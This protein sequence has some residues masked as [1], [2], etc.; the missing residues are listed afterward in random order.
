MYKRQVEELRSFDPQS[1]ERID[2]HNVGRIIRAIEIYR[3]TGMTMTEH[4]EQSRRIPSPYSA[5]II[6]LED[7]YKRQVV[8]NVTCQQNIFLNIQNH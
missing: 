4:V 1:A 3:T 7:V 8:I 2:S 5:C 6:G